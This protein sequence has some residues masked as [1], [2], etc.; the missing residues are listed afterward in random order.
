MKI[1]NSACYTKQNDTAQGGFSVNVQTVQIPGLLTNREGLL[2]CRNTEDAIHQ[3]WQL[4]DGKVIVFESIPI[5][6]PS[7]ALIVYENIDEYIESIR[8][9]DWIN[10]Y[11]NSYN[12][13]DEIVKKGYPFLNLD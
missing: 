10:D 4:A 2:Y 6:Y 7:N 3:S 12:R 5:N 1:N 9:V 13:S 11:E 8:E